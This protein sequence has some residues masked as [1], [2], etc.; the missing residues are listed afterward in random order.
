MDATDATEP[1]DL[2]NVLERREE[3][4]APLAVSQYSTLLRMA[5]DSDRKLVLSFGG[6]S[7]P[8]I[9]ANLALAR[10]IEELGLTDRVDEVWGTSAGSVVGGGWSSG[11]DALGVLKHLKTLDRKDSFDFKALRFA[12]AILLGMWPVRRPMPEGLITGKH[13]RACIEAGLTVHTF[14]ECRVPFRCIACSADGTARPKI[15]RSGPITD[16][17]FSSMT[18][19]GIVIPHRHPDGNYYYDG[20]LVEKTPVPSV[21]AEHLT[22]GDVRDLLILGTHFNSEPQEDIGSGFHHRFLHTIFAMENKVWDHQLREARSRDGVSLLILNPKLGDTSM[23]D[24]AKVDTIYLSARVR[25]ASLLQ[26]A[27]IAQTLGA[28]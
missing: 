9:A 7:V 18:L 21:I 4:E 24:F 10:I 16:A 1:D 15:F 25:F 2:H 8:G 3:I 12:T 5:Q 19:P 13:F 27:R 26:N 14:E 28:S 11:T 6:G 20:G 22:S 23:F 17:V